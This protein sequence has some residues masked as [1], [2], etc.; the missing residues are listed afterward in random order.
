MTS[1]VLTIGTFDGVH[2]GHCFILDL[3]KKKGDEVIV[4]AFDP[5]PA[6][7]LDGREPPGR[8]LSWEDK[9]A[10]LIQ[11]G[12][13]RVV[14]LIPTVETLKLSA[15]QFLDWMV[16]E[17]SPDFVLEGS[18]FRFGHNREGD[19]QFI[20]E[21]GVVNNYQV[22]VV[23]PVYSWVL[24]GAEL[25]VRAHNIRW[26]LEMGRVEEAAQLLGRP[27]SL[28]GKVEPGSKRGRT[29]G[30]PTANL[31]IDEWVKAGGLLPKSGVYAG[32]AT[33]I[34]GENYKAAISVG[35]KPTFTNE[36]YTVETHLL[37][38]EGGLEEYGWLQKVNFC[39]WIRGQYVFDSVND[40]KSQIARDINDVKNSCFLI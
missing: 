26:F 32:E 27:W 4:L 37:D 10:L 3:A 8:L 30:I 15:R 7:A 14:Q 24:S 38:Y 33:G 35:N 21:H 29:I 11:A 23:Q 28:K 13:S 34:N 19:V 31:N 16:T 39:K 25:E 5:H 12:A 6:A 17:Y 22:D 36:K 2:K 20:R 18:D 40:L 1:S 9:K